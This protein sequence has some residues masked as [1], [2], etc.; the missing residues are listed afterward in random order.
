MNHQIPKSLT[1]FIWHFVKPYKKIAIIYIC[2]GIMAGFWSPFNSILIKYI[3]NL[4]PEVQN[5]N[6][7]ML[8]LPVFL[9]VLNFLIFD[10]ITWRSI[11]YIE[12]Y[13]QPIIKGKVSNKM[14]DIS[15]SNSHQF[16]QDKLSGRLS[17]QITKLGDNVERILHLM[18]DFLRGGSLLLVAFITAFYVNVMFFVILLIWFMIFTVFSV[19]KSRVLIHL[20]DNYAKSETLVS[21]QIVDTISNHSN[22]RAF[23]KKE[24]ELLRFNKFLFDNLQSF[25]KQKLFSI[26]LHSIQGLSIALMMGCAGYF[27]IYLY[28]Y[29]LVTIGDFALIFGLTM[30]VGHMTWYTM[31]QVD[32]FNMS[33][34]KCKESLTAL[35]NEPEIQDIENAAI[36]SVKKGKI[37][38][39][40]VKFHYKGAY[41]LFYKESATIQ[42]GQKVGLVGYSGS[43]KTTFVNLILR[44]YDVTDGTI[45]IDNQ[46]IKSV[47]QDSLRT[48]IALIPQDPALFNR[49]LMENIRYGRVNATD[50]DVIEAAKKA[51]AHEFI[52]TLPEGYTTIVGER[53]IKM[54]GGQ[55]QRI[56]IARAILKDAPILILDEATSQLDS[57]TEQHIQDSLSTLMSNKTT[58]V[59]AH[60]LSTLL[61]MDRILVFD[62]GKI[63]EDGHHTELLSKG[64][65]YRTLWESQIGGF[66]PDKKS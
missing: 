2:L 44:L 10:N 22:V 59:I 13:L 43:G 50:Q 14:L 20:A 5:H 3:I 66:L 55:R 56:A 39:R 48:V 58:L 37:E 47:T 19:I 49:S 32:E 61:D 18:A 53:G 7:S 52:S 64:G 9:I 8:I 1:P 16:F 11:A 34:G 40:D 28:K 60:R 4:L 46:D 51:H 63:V 42:A 30:E 25:R 23:A 36:L 41:P 33:V 45:L 29:D 15:L 54:S 21:G 6:V 27:L 12:Y 26:I 65:L 38:F 62:K 24:Y 57:I 17:N 31:L 35:M